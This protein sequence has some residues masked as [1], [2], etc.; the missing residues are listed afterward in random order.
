MNIQ[1]LIDIKV[2]AGEK[3]FELVNIAVYV[4][5]EK[6]VSVVYN[7]HASHSNENIPIFHV[8]KKKK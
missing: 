5:L 6:C 4:W 2:I 1:N 7:A 3:G 8:E